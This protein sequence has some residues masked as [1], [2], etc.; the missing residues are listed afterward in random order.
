M[1]WCQA[2]VLLFPF[3]CTEHV[4][5]APEDLD[6]KTYQMNSKDVPFA[7][8]FDYLNPLS[9]GGPFLTWS[10]VQANTGQF[11]TAKQPPRGMHLFS[12]GHFI[13]SFL[14]V[15][16]WGGYSIKSCVWGAGWGGYC[17][18]MATGSRQK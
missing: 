14:W 8:P 15:A 13:K 4:I 5:L 17:D 11:P 1:Q 16:G 7:K 12:G 3:G 2:L 6:R 10:Q 18:R 9:S